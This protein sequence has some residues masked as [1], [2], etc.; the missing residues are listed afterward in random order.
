MSQ[1][2]ATPDPESL[3]LPGM[4][5]QLAA[6]SMG[7]HSGHSILALH[8]WLDNA[9]S[10]IPLAEMLPEQHFVAL[11]FPGHGHSDHRPSGTVYHFADY[12]ADVAHAVRG[13]DW[14]RF[15]LMGHSL[16]AN[17]ALVFAATFPELVNRLILIDGVGPTSGSADQAVARLRRSV[18]AG[19]APE[20]SPRRHYDDWASLLK[21]RQYASPI[22][23][24]SAELLVRR[25]AREVNGAI[26]MRSDRRLRQP[27]PL[28]LQESVV[29]AFVRAI[30]APVLL[31]LAED[32][33][34]GGRQATRQRITLF[35]DIEV[36]EL[37]GQHH[38]HMDDP[39]A[40]AQV[41]EAFC[42]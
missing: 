31:I 15:T 8:G 1:R 38:L 34:I 41:I 7:A 13:L 40:V 22:S 20:M 14:Q 25:G 9:A 30:R 28:Y 33:V 11:E 24:A 37:P 16:G 4:S 2:P 29:N 12:V 21:A 39:A 32:G 6:L 19:C 26:Q 23:A 3:W 5:G 18:D 36:R 17:V 42:G 10:F 35:E 27:S